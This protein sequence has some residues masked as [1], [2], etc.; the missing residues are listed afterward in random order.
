V[1][2]ASEMTK[3]MLEWVFYLVSDCHIT[4]HVEL[5]RTVHAVSESKNIGLYKGG[6]ENTVVCHIAMLENAHF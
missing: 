6:L 2:T 1:E 5:T 4:E 3:T